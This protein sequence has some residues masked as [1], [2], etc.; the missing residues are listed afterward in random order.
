MDK[1]AAL[2]LTPESPYPTIGGGALRTASL[3]HLARPT[4]RSRCPRLPPTR[5]PRSPAPPSPQA[6]PAT[7]T[8]LNSHITPKPN[9]RASPATSPAPSA[10]ARPCSTASPASN[11]PSHAA[12]A[13]RHY[14]L[15]V[16]EHFWCAPY[17]PLLRPLCARVVLDLH[18]IESAW[19][20]TV[21][22]SA[23]APERLLHRR[24]SNAYLAL[25]RTLLPAFDRVLVTSTLDRGRILAIAPTA[26]LTVF[27]NAIPYVPLPPRAPQNE[28]VFTGNL[29]YQ[30]NLRSRSLLHHPGLAA[31]PPPM[32]LSH[33]DHRRQKSPRR[34][35][36]H[37]RLAQRQPARPHA[38]CRARIAQAQ[39]AV[40]PV[41]SGSGTRIKILEAW[42]AGTPVVSTPL[43]AEGLDCLPGRHLL[44]AESPPAFAQAVSQ[45][46]SDPALAGRLATAG[47]AL[48]ETGYTWPQAWLALDSDLAA[49]AQ[50]I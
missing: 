5:R 43:G 38:R 21:G 37:R 49:P 46:L 7:S 20:R 28:I 16:I 40:V 34:S 8:S 48:Y 22:A 3:A 4:L 6:S 32:A 13:G 23:S 17:L 18:N 42:A 29:E 47:R 11:P 27:P 15:G 45:I 39:A 36:P 44:L 2:F 30:P 9:S 26:R 33:L 10:P 14:A 1:P 31:P 25:E 12:L 50:K 24:F 41:L 19:H 35:K